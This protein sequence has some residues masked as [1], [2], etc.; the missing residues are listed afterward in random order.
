[1]NMP[2]KS[3]G[4]DNRYIWLRKG[5]YE[6]P[7]MYD[8]LQDV[9]ELGEF[10]EKARGQIVHYDFE[11]N[12][13]QYWKKDQHVVGMGVWY[14]G[15]EYPAYV[16][17]TEGEYDVQQ[18]LS[19]M[20]SHKLAAYN[21]V[22]D[23]GWLFKLNR[24]LK[25]KE[26]F[27][28]KEVLG[29]LHCCPLTLFRH[30]ANEG[31]KGQKHSLEVAQE[32]LLGWP[33]DT[34]KL[35]L[36]EALEKNGWKKA[37]MYKLQDIEPE[38]FAYYAATDAMACGLVWRHLVSEA[39]RIGKPELVEFHLHD[40][41]L[42]L[43][44]LIL[45][46]WEGIPVNKAKLKAALIVMFKQNLEIELE[47]RNHPEV[48][49]HIEEWERQKFADKFYLNITEKRRKVSDAEIVKRA[50]AD[51]SQA[52]L[53]ILETEA[54]EEEDSFKGKSKV[55]SP[56]FAPSPNDGGG[57]EV[58]E[59]Y[60]TLKA[61]GVNQ[62]IPVFN[63]D[64]PHDRRWL[65]HTKLGSS[66]KTVDEFE[67]EVWKFTY[68]GRTFY[69]P[70][71]KSGASPTGKEI[72][73]VF[74]DL[75]KLFKK[76]AKATKLYSYAKAYYAAA[77]QDGKIHPTFSPSGT[78]T[79]RLSA[80]GGINAQ[81]LPKVKEFLEAFEA[82]K[83]YVFFGADFA[84]LE[85]V[86]QAEFSGDKALKELYTSGLNHDVHFYNAARIHPDPNVRRQLMERYKPDEAVIEALKAEF[87]KERDFC[88]GI[89]FGFDYGMGA[90]KMYRNANNG[91]FDLA[92]DQAKDVVAKYKE[93]YAGVYQWGETLLAEWKHRNG[94]IEDA[95]GLPVAV[96]EK[97]TKDL[98]SRFVQ[99]SGHYMLMA[100]NERINVLKEERSIYEQPVICDLHDERIGLI[101][102]K[103]I[104]AMEQI[105]MDALDW[106]NDDLQPIIPFKINTTF[107]GTLWE[108]KKS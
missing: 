102:E 21:N 8:H 3:V 103:D 67:R 106:L 59:R 51:Y 45:Q 107:G 105:Y 69:L 2:V 49:P 101:K 100:L 63:F 5:N 53:E 78:A 47:L 83:G 39:N 61:E 9:V 20:L 48:K 19:I 26:R 50:L 82:P 36:K 98:V 14:E 32:T 108:F 41:M 60:L 94:W 57:M 25:K 79:G 85:K 84:A 43:R 13:L 64:S 30:A 80:T 52:D 28:D 76:Y 7:R 97:L 29:A 4:N 12:G 42:Q 75:G 23:G 18:F 56:F 11:T 55:S 96:P 31:V 104:E 70:P 66:I 86:V 33:T 22:F 46:A 72:F 65:M 37:D 99:R 93:T 16:R 6:M 40:E 73:P 58:V 77:I 71:T 95:M 90:Y 35:W 89:S 1:M 68:N 88:K 17:L 54:E 27:T 87:K 44:E 81:Q 10:L 92:F 38:A 24:S 91:G 74:G 34:Q 62:K 15:A